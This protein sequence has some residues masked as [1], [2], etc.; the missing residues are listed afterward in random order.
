M[1]TVPNS[2]QKLLHAGGHVWE[3]TPKVAQLPNSATTPGGAVAAFSRP[4]LLPDSGMKY[5][6]ICFYY[7][8]GWKALGGGIPGTENIAG[9]WRFQIGYVF[10]PEPA[11]TRKHTQGPRRYCK[12]EPGLF[13]K[14]YLIEHKQCFCKTLC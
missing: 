6:I 3:I 10:A 9:A 2:E 4:A 5:Y 11:P 1:L 13:Y 12:T 14:R 8:F 7:Y